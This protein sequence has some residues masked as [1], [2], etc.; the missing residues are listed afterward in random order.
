MKLP[1]SVECQCRC[2][3]RDSGSANNELGVSLDLVSDTP[4][5]KSGTVACTADNRLALGRVRQRRHQFRHSL[6]RKSEGRRKLM[7]RL[8]RSV[9]DRLAITSL[10][11]MGCSCRCRRWRFRAPQ[12]THPAQNAIVIIYSLRLQTLPSRKPSP[13]PGHILWQPLS[14]DAKVGMQGKVL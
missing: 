11:L 3:Y 1:S 6:L 2:R 8:W 12:A 5:F 4:V 7:K 13:C 9:A 10:S 14:R